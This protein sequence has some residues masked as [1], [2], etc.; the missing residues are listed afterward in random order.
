M[1]GQYED[2][3]EFLLSA[4]EAALE[5]VRHRERVKQLEWRCRRLSRDEFGTR[6]GG[7]Y[8]SGD[9]MLAMLADARDE[10]LR[11]LAREQERLRQVERFIEGVEGEGVLRMVLRLRY[12]EFLPWLQVQRAM[13]KAGVWYSERQT[14]RLHAKA[15]EA[16][17]AR[18]EKEMDAA[19]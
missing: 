19:A 10:E 17:A 16:A 1:Q 15:L 9:E 13:N 3:K 2:V 6:G 4:R 18:W 7:N 12:L 8:D 5:L 11:A 14:M